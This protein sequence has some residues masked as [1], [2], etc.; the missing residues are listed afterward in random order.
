V[1]LP[2]KDLFAGALARLALE[3]LVTRDLALTDLELPVGLLTLLLLEK[4]FFELW[5]GELVLRL[6]FGVLALLPVLLLRFGELVKRLPLSLDLLLAVVPPEE[7][8]LDIGNPP[9][10]PFFFEF[11]LRV[12]LRLGL[13]RLSNNSII[14][15]RRN[16]P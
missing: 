10:R 6:C 11:E 4:F 9:A 15:S 14:L 7:K 2:E 8:D 13:A 16:I 1:D 3:D 5:F 12:V